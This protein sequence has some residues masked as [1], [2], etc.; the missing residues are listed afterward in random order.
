MPFKHILV[1]TD[2]GDASERAVDVAVELA[3]KLGAELTLVHT[4]EIPGYVYSAMGFSPMDL[5]TPVE[6]VAKQQFEV[7]LATL[8]KRLPRAK[9]VL[10][11]GDPRAEIRAAVDATRADLVV[12]GTH[13][14]RGLTHALLGSVAE[15]TVQTSTVPVLTI[16]AAADAAKA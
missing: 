6:V 16:R 5:L 1:P 14:R 12:M 2:F 15:R 13:G 9:G 4:Y 10:R 11:K 7:A 8:R 3:E